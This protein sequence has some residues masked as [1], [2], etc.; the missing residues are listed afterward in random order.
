MRIEFHIHDDG[1]VSLDGEHV[2]DL[3]TGDDGLAYV[4]FREGHKMPSGDVCFC[5]PCPPFYSWK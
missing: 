2:A 5:G 4:E 1:V 3:T